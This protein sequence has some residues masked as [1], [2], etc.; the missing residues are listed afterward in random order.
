[1]T[2]SARPEDPEDLRRSQRQALS[3]GLGKAIRAILEAEAPSEAPPAFQPTSEKDGPASFLE[4]DEA[5]A[6]AEHTRQ[7]LRLLRGPKLFLRVIPTVASSERPAA[8]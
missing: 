8:R 1:M 7:Q 2:Y 4:P 5:V 6:E 3:R